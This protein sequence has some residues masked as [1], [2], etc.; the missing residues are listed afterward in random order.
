MAT[1][2]TTDTVTTGGGSTTRTS[3]ADGSTTT[4]VKDASGKVVSTNTTP[5]SAT[6]TEFVPP[7][8]AD[9]NG[10]KGKIK[11]GEQYFLSD[12]NSWFVFDDSIRGLL[13]ANGANPKDIA[14]SWFWINQAKSRSWFEMQGS[15]Y[16]TWTS[17][18]KGSWTMKP[19]SEITPD[20]REID[21]SIVVLKIKPPESGKIVKEDVKLVSKTDG[22]GNK[23][24]GVIKTTV[25][26]DS[27]GKQTTVVVNTLDGT[28]TVAEKKESLAAGIKKL[29]DLINAIGTVSSIISGIKSL[30]SGGGISSVS[31]GS[32][33]GSGSYVGGPS[34]LV[35]IT[36]NDGQSYLIDK[37]DFPTDTIAKLEA[38]EAKINDCN[39]IPDYCC[40][41][42][43]K[44]PTISTTYDPGCTLIDYTNQ[45]SP[46]G[47]L[48]AAL[49]LFNSAKSPEDTFTAI[50]S[51]ISALD[52]SKLEP[53]S[54]PGDSGQATF[55]N[56]IPKIPS[57]ASLLGKLGQ[58]KL[59]KIPTIPKLPG[60]EGLLD[61]TGI[62]DLLNKIPEI[63]KMPDISKIL[64]LDNLKCPPGPEDL[65]KDNV[66][67][68]QA[69]NE[70]KKAKSTFDQL[71]NGDVAMNVIGLLMAQQCTS[72]TGKGR[73]DP[74]TGKPI[75]DK[76]P[77]D[78][79]DTC[80]QNMETLKNLKNDINTVRAIT[81][82]VSMA[83]DDPMKALIAYDLLQKNQYA[84][85]NNEPYEG[86]PLQMIADSIGYAEDANCIFG[87][88]KENPLQA[89][90]DYEK[91]KTKQAQQEE[92]DKI[93][94]GL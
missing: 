70:A 6:T 38:H 72:N 47:S 61:S 90:V 75:F 26:E 27:D 25:H 39:Y 31:G 30:A 24:T 87:S 91:L 2:T 67:I 73:I 52:Y 18:Q 35:I 65:D 71:Q 94:F 10:P 16:T 62:T 93:R 49:S 12:S 63:P 59:P 19:I 22:D 68:L 80:V 41:T 3:N 5:I 37:N 92:A 81:N 79:K 58:T 64:G 17:T 40:P 8:T 32:Y 7:E 11:Y 88:F 44:M 54:G 57:F 45:S 48:L 14:T 53:H 43:P 15:K 84:D 1:I 20:M 69:Y 34:S 50:E 76:T 28:K 9:P 89:L 55:A 42:D 21:M 85:I 46:A 13:L 60:L 4:T 78:V 51:V 36:T 56:C 86:S 33:A 83:K 74:V 66:S 23:S 77:E 29:T 82:I